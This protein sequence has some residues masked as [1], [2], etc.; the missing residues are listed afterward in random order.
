MIKNPE[1][2]GDE[3]QAAENTAWGSGVKKR[4]SEPQDNRVNPIILA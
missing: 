1:M 4:L 3:R 2:R